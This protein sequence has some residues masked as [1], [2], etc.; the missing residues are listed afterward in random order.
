MNTK[1][2]SI[3]AG[4]IPLLLTIA[5]EAAPNLG[6]EWTSWQNGVWKDISAEAREVARKHPEFKVNKS[7]KPITVAFQV[8]NDHEL[9]SRNVGASSGSSD[10]DIAIGEIL[11]FSKGHSAYLFP[12]GTREKLVDCEV[13]FY[14]D[15]HISPLIV[16]KANPGEKFDPRTI[17]VPYKSPGPNGL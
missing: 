6:P 13:T 15:G 17:A 11:F 16:N 5:V 2:T 4:A 1:T 7:I 10:F 9:A 14:P 12:K 8:T 3:L